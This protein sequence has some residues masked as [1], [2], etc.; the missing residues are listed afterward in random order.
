[1][2]NSLADL[3][4]GIAKREAADPER[5]PLESVAA[6][7]RA[8]IV[9]A[10]FDPSLGGEGATCRQ[11][12][13]TIEAIATAS[14]SLALIASMP[15]GLAGVLALGG[16]GPGD[17]WTRSWRDSIEKIAR[18][19][20]DGKVYAA[21]NSEKG[22]G[23][24]LAA[25]KTV[26]TR[27]DSGQFRISGDKILATS[28][29]HSAVFFSTAKVDDND[30]PGAGIVELFFVDAH[31]PGV[32]IANDWNGF[33][34]RSS[35]S[36]SVRYENAA[37]ANLFGFPNYLAAMQPIQYW[38]H[39]FAAIP[40]GCAKSIFDALGSPAPQSPALRMRLAEAEMRYEAM[41]AY[42]LDT[43]DEFRASAG[44]AYARKVLRMKTYVTQE[45]TKLSAEL[46][47]LSGGRH[48]SRN[49]TVARTFADAFAGTALRPPLSLGLET[50]QE[51]FGAD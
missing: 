44:G 49:S 5:Y 1:M 35:E 27:D 20:Q 24:S 51:Q 7:Y 37:V 17:E 34:M 11:A 50:L 46:F 16:E 3:L 12:S 33:G 8:N 15:L 6:L 43:A 14:P 38:Y 36:Q 39:L 10:P 41:R 42:L 47:A 32:K 48:Y 13:E 26:A 30:L 21:C 28:G 25:T 29:E 40:L 18:D 23:G 2:L 22:A 9:Q 19:F 45:A 31:A 4:P